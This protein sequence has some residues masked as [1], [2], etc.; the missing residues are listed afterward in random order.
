[1]RYLAG[2]CFLGICAPVQQHSFMQI[3]ATRS[4]EFVDRIMQILADNDV[5]VVQR[6][7]VPNSLLHDSALL[8]ICR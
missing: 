2:P 6:C 7:S 4:V 1:M 3:D 8:T 5:T